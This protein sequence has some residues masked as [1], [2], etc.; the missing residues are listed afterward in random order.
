MTHTCDDSCAHTYSPCD[1]CGQW[2]RAL[3]HSAA[4]CRAT[5]EYSPVSTV[6]DADD[7]NDYK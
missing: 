1:T 4:E 2:V 5:R 3:Y 6:V 7:A